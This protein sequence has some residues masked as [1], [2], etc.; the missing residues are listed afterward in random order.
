MGGATPPIAVAPGPLARARTGWL[1]LDESDN[2]PARFLAYFIAALS[3]AEGIEAT[4]GEGALGMLQSPQPP[5][6]ED[7]LT[8]LIKEVA[9]VLD[10][11][12]LV[13]DD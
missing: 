6:T 4:I 13:L 8:S 11:I 1:S 7:V 9:T 2:D 3:Q 5:P 12:I 10:R